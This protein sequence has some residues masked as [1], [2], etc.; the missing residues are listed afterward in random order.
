MKDVHLIHLSSKITLLSRIVILLSIFILTQYGGYLP[1]DAEAL[2]LTFTPLT[3]FLFAAYI[4]FAIKYPYPVPKEEMKNKKQII[5]PLLI[6]YIMSLGFI[7]LSALKPDLL[8]F[9][10]LQLIL[11][12]IESILAIHAAF[13][14]PQ[15]FTRFPLQ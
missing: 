14:L 3:V 4:R 2:Y 13:T 9:A 5:S 15:L 6:T 8:S 1:Q 7:V 10:S 12:G 11:V